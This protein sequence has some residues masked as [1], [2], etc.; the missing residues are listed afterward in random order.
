MK[1]IILF[2][3]CLI[4]ISLTAQ[5]ETAYWH[6]GENA[7][8]HFTENG[9]TS[10]SNS[11]IE[12][13]EGSA[14]ISD[15]NGNLLFYTDGTRVFDRTNNVMQNGS[16]L[17]GN[18]SSTQS[19]I[20]VPRPGNPGKYF[21]FTVDKPD[22][23]V[24]SNDPIEGVNYSEIDMS[25]NNGNGAIIENR[26]NLPLVTYDPS[27]PTENEFKSSEKISAVVGGDC[28]SY[29][30][31]TPFTNKFYAFKVTSAGVNT[32]PVVS[33]VP[34]SIRPIL[35][36][37][38]VNVTAPGYMKISPD[39]TK[40]AAAYSATA[41]G[42]PR[43]GGGKQNGKVFLYDFDDNTGKVSN[44]KLILANTYPYGVEFSPNSNK[45]Y[46]TAS[47]FSSN[48]VFQSS[49]LI[50]FNIKAPS[51][52][53]SET[54]IHNSSNVAGGIQLAM[55]G[56]IY[57]VGYPVFI[58]SHQKLS[59]IHNPN[60][61]AQNINYSHNSI[62]LDNGY[63]RLGLPPF[64]QSLFNN[65]FDVENL[66]LGSETEFTITGK[67]N[68]DSVRWD[69][70]DGSTSTDLNPTHVFA[71]PGSYKV[72]LTVFTNG[73]PSNPSCEEV[74][75][76]ELPESEDYELNQCDVS[77]NNPSDG[78]T[79]FNLQEIRENIN[80]PTGLL[81]FY[82][83]E[84]EEAAT[85]DTNNQNAINNIFRNSSPSQELTLKSVAFNT[86]CYSLS[87]VT[88]STTS[89]IELDPEPVFGC[90][91]EDNQ[92]Q[93][94]LEN[95]ESK[96]ITEL[97]L[98]EDVALDFFENEE[99]AIYG[100]NSLPETYNGP[101]TTLFIKA[102]KSGKCYGFGTVELKLN[103]FPDLQQ[104]VIVQA[105]QNEFPITIGEEISITN[106]EMFNYVWNTGETG[107]QLTIQSSGVYTLE[108]TD[109]NIGCGRSVSFEVQELAAPE[110]ANIDITNQ[111]IDNSLDIEVE[112][113]TLNSVTF[114]L[115]DPSGPYQ[116][117]PHFENVPGGVHTVYAKDENGCAIANLEVTLF[118]FPNYFTP[119]N[120]GYNDFWKPY[121]VKAP[122]YQ[123]K[124]I[125]LFDR[126]GKLL[127]EL[128]SGTKGWDGNFN[129]HPMPA[130]DYWF[131][132][133]LENGKNFK[134][135]FSLI[136]EN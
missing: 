36:D 31:V 123:I 80:D 33:T 63:V 83:Y 115:D 50:Q 127:K 27:N 116:E 17:K 104:M 42:S 32:N 126:Y 110:I 46:I 64:V 28:I 91:V 51:I 95:I 135:H 6:F 45:L 70:G 72:S 107:R 53:N 48:D 47:N 108:V 89:T 109:P 133:I 57:R 111:G 3:F 68:F 118:G 67:E 20:I 119:N 131:K 19:A 49:S 39:G 82:F 97:S 92:G 44:E 94:N 75:I 16:E 65:N 106:S 1:K 38:D 43:T 69:F 103:S 58:D 12:T 24:V 55:D 34:N 90:A 134:G 98:P 117:S 129:G 113:D 125:Y 2:F 10:I 100:A 13:S 73:I 102:R 14:S 84:S 88:L 21:L 37:N 120:D 59:V 5:K 61:D 96:I 40:I 41:L 114:S 35:N 74:I 101:P 99:D 128:F 105:C 54:E 66:C 18:P 22:Y 71:E 25:L 130:D 78:I 15:L 122:D 79:T 26:K 60:E 9:V 62:T 11:S 86:D 136:R 23:S 7:G 112:N 93:F 8:L 29:W 132:I 85:N 81:Q 77:D 87:K 121:E 56:K 30:V 124:G 4:S 76:V 52:G